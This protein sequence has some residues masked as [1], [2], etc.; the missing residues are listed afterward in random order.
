MKNLQKGSLVNWWILGV[1]VCIAL[2]LAYPL[3]RKE[4]VSPD[5]QTMDAYSDKAQDTG[6][7]D[8]SQVDRVIDDLPNPVKIQPSITIVSPNGG[9]AL[10]QDDEYSIVWDYAGLE[11]SSL[12]TIGFRNESEDVCWAGKAMASEKRYVFTPSKA[13]CGGSIAFLKA[14]MK[15]RAQVIVDSYAGGKGVADTSD[16]YFTIAK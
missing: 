2:F 5:R 10:R 11:G 9:D 1:L 4:P 6:R 7:I 3:I 16:A 13:K 14:G 15:L 12:I 8:Q